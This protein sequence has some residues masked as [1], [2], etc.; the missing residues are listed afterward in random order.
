MWL[1]KLLP[2]VVVKLNDGSVKSHCRIPLRRLSM[3]NFVD[4]NGELDALVDRRLLEEQ[5]LERYRKA[6]KVALLWI[7][8][9]IVGGV[10]VVFALFTFSPPC[11]MLG[12]LGSPA[13]VG[14]QLTIVVLSLL[15]VP[16]VISLISYVIRIWIAKSRIKQFEINIENFRMGNLSTV[17]DIKVELDALADRR[18]GEEQALERYRK[19]RK[20]ALLWIF[21]WI[22]GGVPVVFALVTF[23]R[24]CQGIG[25]FESP[26]VVW[27]SNMILVLPCLVVPAVIS[28]ISYV[29]MI[30]IA[31]SRIRQFEKI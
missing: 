15:V 24:Q 11:R 8:G 4:L 21:G 7:F 5:A 13:V 2:L 16:G 28:L 12:C 10:A 30:R 29:I 18:L 3:S 9:W 17:A 31:K 19:A 26:A 25:C 14:S 20:V 6:R 22:A 23:L 1:L 27:G